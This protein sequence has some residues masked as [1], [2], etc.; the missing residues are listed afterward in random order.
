MGWVDSM[1]GYVF[2]GGSFS[3]RLLS[4]ARPARNNVLLLL[5]CLGGVPGLRPTV[6]PF[7]F[8]EPLE[9]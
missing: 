7:Y 6:E 9:P 1:G 4:W 5:L 3:G 8:L 2:W